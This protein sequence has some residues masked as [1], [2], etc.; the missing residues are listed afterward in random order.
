MFSAS[1]V[2]H[3]VTLVLGKSDYNQAAAQR[4]AKILPWGVP[5]R[6]SRPKT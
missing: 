6:A 4:L 5:A 1:R 3:D 2:N